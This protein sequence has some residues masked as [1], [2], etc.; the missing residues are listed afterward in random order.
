MPTANLLLVGKVIAARGLR[1]ELVVFSYTD[2]KA[3]LLTYKHLMLSNDHNQFIK[4]IKSGF[5]RSNKLIIQLTDINDRSA[6]E[7]LISYKIFITYEQLAK[8]QKD[9]Y[10]WYQLIGLQVINQQNELLGIVDNLMATGANDVLMLKPCANSIDGRSR[11]L[12]Y[13]KHCVLNIN[14]DTQI[15]NVEWDSDF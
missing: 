14:L 6:A 5:E 7:K 1:G 4:K 12:P 8:L 2:P 10:Y 15:I 11:L 3:N 13:T 9:E